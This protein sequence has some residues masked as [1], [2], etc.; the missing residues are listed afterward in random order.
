MNK[1]TKVQRLAIYLRDGFACVYCGAGIEDSATL[2]LD[3]IKHTLTK[4]LHDSTNV[5][6]ACLR[7]THKRSGYSISAY[8]R[9]VA[10]ISGLDLCPI[11]VERHVRNCARRNAP[12]KK[13][14]A[15][16]AK[17]GAFTAALA[18]EEE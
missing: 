18:A 14:K 2:T 1:I 3:Y 12:I 13:A 16:A 11:V 8:S 7:C 4:G 10:E 6:T 5:V 17:R 15:L 9:I